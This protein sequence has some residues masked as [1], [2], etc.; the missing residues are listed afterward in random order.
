MAEVHHLSYDIFGPAVHHRVVWVWGEHG[1]DAL[2]IWSSVI[3]FL[4]CL[5]H[6]RWETFSSPW[7]WGRR[8][9]ESRDDVGFSVESCVWIISPYIGMRSVNNRKWLKKEKNKHHTGAGQRTASPASHNVYKSASSALPDPA[10]GTIQSAVTGLAGLKYF[11]KYCARASLIG[12]SPKKPTGLANIWIYI[13]EEHFHC[14]D[15]DAHLQLYCRLR[16]FCRYQ[17]F[18][19]SWECFRHWQGRCCRSRFPLVKRE[20]WRQASRPS[21]SSPHVW[22]AH[23]WPNS[24][25]E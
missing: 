13:N 22:T 16:R 24:R 12:P 14:F 15:I 21:P 1:F 19:P 7:Q 9:D 20:H 5:N 2:R 8:L 11:V 23:S 18:R 4:H 25:L 10:V 6:G 17:V 3:C